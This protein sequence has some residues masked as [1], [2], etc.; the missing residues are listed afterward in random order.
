MM[1]V[2]GVHFVILLSKRQIARSPG[3]G[4]FSNMYLVK[5]ADANQFN[6]EESIVF[7]EAS[8]EIAI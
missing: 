8:G 6:E 1:V 3:Q 4:A 7:L 5:K 2:K